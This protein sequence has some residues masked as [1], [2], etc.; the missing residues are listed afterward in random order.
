L[1]AGKARF[2]RAELRVGDDEDTGV[3]LS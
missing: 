3:R 1:C 2:T